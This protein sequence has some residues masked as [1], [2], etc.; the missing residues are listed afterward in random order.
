MFAG[1]EL[2]AEQHRA[3]VVQAFA[4]SVKK[5]DGMKPSAVDA[6]LRDSGFRPG[7]NVGA[8]D[9]ALEI[10]R[11]FRAR[12]GGGKHRDFREAVTLSTRD[13]FPV[14]HAQRPAALYFCRRGIDEPARARFVA[15]RDVNRDLA[16]PRL[17]EDTAGY[18]PDLCRRPLGPPDAE[19]TFSLVAGPDR[20]PCERTLNSFLRCCTDVDRVGRFLVL[21]VGLS[22]V[23]RAHLVDRYPFLEF[24]VGSAGMSPA[25]QV[26]RL[27]EA[28]GGRYWLHSGQGWQ[29]FAADPL[30][31]R[32][33]SVLQAEPE[34]F[35]VGINVGDATTLTGTA[36]PAETTRTAVGRY[37][38][39]DPGSDS[40]S[41]GPNMV[42]VDRFRAR[43]GDTRFTGA[44]LD[45]VLCTMIMDGE[46]RHDR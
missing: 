27:A 22:E 35:R 41:H 42:D 16:V 37:V 23:D 18:P 7:D 39:T 29:Y 19:V 6:R 5:I 30:I 34:V 33:S 43:S 36:A 32:L 14:G 45:E 8:D 24:L 13:G 1:L 15:N 17:L 40:E 25:D 44:T 28:I 2:G 11:Q 46:Q 12:L 31:T 3:R 10:E 20:E 38:L 21:D 4:E 9:R 26:D